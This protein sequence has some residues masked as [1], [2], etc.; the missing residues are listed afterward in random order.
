MLQCFMMGVRSICD[1]SDKRL[2][3]KHMFVFLYK[4]LCHLGTKLRGQRDNIVFN[5]GVRRF[6]DMIHPHSE[7]NASEQ[8]KPE[9]QGQCPS[10]AV[11][12]RLC[13]V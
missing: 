12:F 2:S 11:F 5:H 9:Q 7:R 6:R 8:S 1:Q 4:N 10:Y 13:G 3:G